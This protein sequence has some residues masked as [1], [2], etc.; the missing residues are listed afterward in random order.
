VKV[1]ID[2]NLPAEIGYTL[3]DFGHDVDTV[4]NEH[5][6]GASDDQVWQA[7][8]ATGR[9]LVT[10]DLDFSDVRKF[11]PGSHSS[12][13]LVRLRDPDRRALIHRLTEVF[14]TE[15]VSGWNRCFV[16]ISDRKVRVR[17]PVPPDSTGKL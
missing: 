3:S 9:I 5:L 6:G 1:K 14:R 4:L 15:D 17:R 11:S 10:Q 8:Q 16:V 7:T 12:L 13:I 2:E